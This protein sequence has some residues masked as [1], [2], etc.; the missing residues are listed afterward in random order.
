MRGRR[1]LVDHAGTNTVGAEVPRRGDIGLR[2]AEPRFVDVDDLRDARSSFLE[3]PT[4]VSFV[5]SL[6][7]C[8]G[9]GPAMTNSTG[10]HDGSVELVGAVPRTRHDE[11]DGIVLVP[12]VVWA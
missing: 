7:R 10:F 2:P 5:H 1:D 4:Y 3:N 9:I 12:N 11:P 6:L 8:R